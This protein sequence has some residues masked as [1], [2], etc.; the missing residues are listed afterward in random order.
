[1]MKELIDKSMI[2]MQKNFQKFFDDVEKVRVGRINSK[3]V[4]SI[5]IFYSGN[6][7]LLSYISTVNVY[8]NNSVIVTPFDKFLLKEI[9]KEIRNNGFNSVIIRDGIK[10]TFPILS[11]E[12]RQ[13][14]IKYIFS[15][16][17]SNKVIIRNIR[18][19]FKNSLQNLVKNKTIT[20]DEE[21]LSLKSIQKITD[22]FIDDIDVIVKKK[23]KEILND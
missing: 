2:I 7:V 23:E 18:R 13:K 12:A 14:L 6:E 1:M 10:V 5:R 4:S 11:L 9:D 20:P 15:L 19:D 21:K 22:K 17:E 3:F 16:S 8:D